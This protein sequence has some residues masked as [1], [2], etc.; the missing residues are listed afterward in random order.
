MAV[1]LSENN[2]PMVESIA[3]IFA[4]ITVIVI[5]LRLFSRIVIVHYVGL[6]DGEFVDS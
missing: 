5:S 3:I 4:V 1:D 2:G 6:D